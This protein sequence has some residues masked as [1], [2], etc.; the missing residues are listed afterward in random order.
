MSRATPQPPPRHLP[1]RPL[2]SP[3]GPLRAIL[4]NFNIGKRVDASEDVRKG[5][6]HELTR[7]FDLEIEDRSHSLVMLGELS[8]VCSLGDA[9][10]AETVD[11]HQ[12]AARA[13]DAF[14]RAI[15]SVEAP[16]PSMRSVQDV[17]MRR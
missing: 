3:L 13:R 12:P 6:H 5:F 4:H 8:E 16:G 9:A 15:F 2:Q 10:G 7:N 14:E 11:E 1:P 17:L